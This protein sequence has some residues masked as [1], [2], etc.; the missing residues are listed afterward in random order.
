MQK[1]NTYIFLL[2]VILTSVLYV[3]IYQYAHINIS[4]RWSDP[5]VDQHNRPS[6]ALNELLEK[7]GIV[8]DGSF[9]SIVAATQK[10]QAEGGWLRVPGTERW[11]CPNKDIEENLLESINELGVLNEIKPSKTKYKYAVILGATAVGMR[12]RLA[13]LKKLHENGVVFDN[14][15][16]LVGERPRSL[17]VESDEVLLDAQNGIIDFDEK[18]SF[19]GIFPQTETEIA[20]LVYEQ[21]E[22]S[23]A[24]RSI[25]V[26]FIDTPMQKTTQGSL[27]RPTTEDTIYEWQRSGS[28]PG[29]VLAISS[30][31]HV[32]R[33]R[34]IICSIMPEEFFIECVGPSVDYEDLNA[35]VLLDSLARDLYT[36]HNKKKS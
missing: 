5:F 2:S 28:T 20:R 18:W 35:S 15:V 23:A 33:Q 26:T 29:T 31:P 8:H 27:R 25:P 7:T 1:Y 16:F 36:L 14:L 21:S 24:F 34:L 19:S 32:Y 9:D 30:Q 4:E 12:T 17:A 22:L 11:D 3:S 13:Y 6:K 10:T